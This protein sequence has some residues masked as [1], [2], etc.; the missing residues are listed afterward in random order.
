M[1][2]FF[3]LPE[4]IFLP[5]SELD[6][7]VVRSSIRLDQFLFSLFSNF[8]VF[9]LIPIGTVQLFSRL[10][11]PWFLKSPAWIQNVPQ[12]SPRWLQSLNDMLYGGQKY[13]GFLSRTFANNQ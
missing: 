10:R 3:V 1:V 13:S 12:M 11:L 5:I 4:A 2:A 7:L 8:K 9:S 6:P